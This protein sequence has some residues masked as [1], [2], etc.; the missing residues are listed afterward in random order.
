MKI[1]LSA[2]WKTNIKRIFCMFFLFVCNSSFAETNLPLWELGLG[3]GYVNSAIFRGASERDHFYI[4][5]PYF[6]Y[7]GNRLR[8]DE[9]GVRGKI[10]ESRRLKLDFSVAGQV[11]VSA[12][13]DGPRSGMPNLEPIGEI[14]PS[15]DYVFWRSNLHNNSIWIRLPWRFVLSFG[16]PLI[17]YRGWSFAPYI[18]FVKKI[19]TKQNTR[20]ALAIGPIFSSSQYHDYF[21]RVRRNYVTAVREQYSAGGGYS[22]SRITFS[23]TSNMSTYWLGAMIRYDNLTAAEFETSPLVSTKKYLVVGLTVAWIFSKSK[24]QVID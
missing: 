22:G 10:A 9:E 24:I 21:Y 11:P 3:I 23:I 15:L 17:A 7:R 19:P 14:G 6:T 20:I 2:K 8:V 13:D 4:P 18:D 1:L 5:Y 16:D 12:S